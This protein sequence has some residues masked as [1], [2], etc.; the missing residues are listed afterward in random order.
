MN[1]IDLK[2]EIRNCQKCELYQSRTYPV[3]GSGNENSNL[4]FVGEA[5]GQEEDETG[6]PFVGRSGEKLTQIINAL[7]LKRQDVYIA[8]IIKCR[9]PGNRNPSKE[10]ARY[11]IPY[12]YKQIDII[13][14]KVI[15]TL[16]A[17]PFKYLLGEE[18]IT[19]KHGQ[20]FD[21]SKEKSIWIMPMYHPAFLLRSPDKCKDTWEDV[22]ELKRFLNGGDK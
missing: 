4:M 11:C 2:E 3:I 19:H 14:P 17:I 8:N 21:F 9:P 12:L 5:P 13:E 20:W 6:K 18:G 10:E 15:I 22:K 7:D 16:G 1:M